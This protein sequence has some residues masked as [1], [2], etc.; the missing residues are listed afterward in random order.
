MRWKGGSGWFYLV[1]EEIAGGKVGEAV[2][3]DDFLA[4]GAL[5]GSGAPQHPDHWD[6]YLGLGTAALKMQGDMSY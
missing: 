6:V 2:L 3:G 5:A 4:L 1:T